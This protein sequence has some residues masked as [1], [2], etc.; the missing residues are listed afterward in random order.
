MLDGRL[1][2]PCVGG[3]WVGRGCM[4]VL[5]CVT[6]VRRMADSGWGWTG[7]HLDG[8]GEKNRV[9]FGV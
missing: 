6:R 1:D 4:E 3:R 8:R 9:G 5:D 2:V 7:I